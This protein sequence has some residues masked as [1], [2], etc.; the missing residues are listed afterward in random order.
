MAISATII[1]ENALTA[2]REDGVSRLI[3]VESM[4]VGKLLTLNGTTE[5]PT[6]FFPCAKIQYYSQ[7]CKCCH[8][9]GEG[10][11]DVEKGAVRRERWG[12]EAAVSSRQ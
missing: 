9:G 12:M 2:L 3:I 1:N 7:P 5:V 11:Y 10:G 8:N 4:M 6:V